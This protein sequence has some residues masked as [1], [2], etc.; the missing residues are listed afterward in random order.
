MSASWCGRVRDERKRRSRPRRPACSSPLL[1][2][3]LI[4][5]LLCVAATAS[6]VHSYSAT[7]GLIYRGSE[8]RDGGWREREYGLWYGKGTWVAYRHESVSYRGPAGTPGRSRQ[9]IVL[10]PVDPTTTP[11]YLAAKPFLGIRATHDAS[12]VLG[13][14]WVVPA[15]WPVIAFGLPP[16]A[17]LF[18]LRPLLT[19]RRRRRLGLCVVCGYDLKASAGRCPECGAAIDH[20]RPGATLST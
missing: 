1:A 7:R 2:A 6:W 20:P 16:I 18:T 4:S 14:W 8:L 15:W 9:W 10:P 5:A 3:V 11:G 13:D 17:W 19:R 12:G